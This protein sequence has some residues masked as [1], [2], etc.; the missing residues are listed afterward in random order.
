M[1]LYCIVYV[2]H[3]WLL[4]DIEEEERNEQECSN[5]SGHISSSACK[6]HKNVAWYD[7]DSDIAIDD[8]KDIG[9]ADMND[10]ISTEDDSKVLHH[11]IA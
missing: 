5:Y 11:Y 9:D 4:E 1:C 8:I 6:G 2:T 10:D 7:D 3:K